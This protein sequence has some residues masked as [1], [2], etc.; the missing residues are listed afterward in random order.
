MGQGSAVPAFRAEDLQGYSFHPAS[1]A[2]RKGS[3]VRAQQL[4]RESTFLENNLQ[5]S[6]A[7]SAQWPSLFSKRFTGMTEHQLHQHASACGSQDQKCLHRSLQEILQAYEQL[8]LQPPEAAGEPARQG[9]SAAS[10]QE[11]QLSK[12]FLAEWLAA[13]TACRGEK[14]S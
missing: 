7:D 13:F 14:L 8:T 3:M 10:I 5:T 2:G 6:L 11:L 1:T 12:A 4:L 9:P